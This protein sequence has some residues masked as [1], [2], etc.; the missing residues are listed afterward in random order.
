MPWSSVT[1]NIFLKTGR[2]PFSARSG[3]GTKLP[4]AF[5]LVIGDAEDEAIVIGAV[6]VQAEGAV[7]AKKNSLR[8]LSYTVVKLEPEL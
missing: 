5:S 4:F 7:R 8:L 2:A 3:L 6:S 1:E